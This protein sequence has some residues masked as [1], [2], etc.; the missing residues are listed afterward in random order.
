MLISLSP[1]CYSE[2]LTF[3]LISVSG[4]GYLDRSNLIRL[5]GLSI[6]PT[7]L[8]ERYLSSKTQTLKPGHLAEMS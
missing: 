3:L 4:V 6:P 8:K 5:S 2:F 1:A 7:T